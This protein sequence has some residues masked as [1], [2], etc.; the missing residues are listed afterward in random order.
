MKALEN[1]G[2]FIPEAIKQHPTD[3]GQTKHYDQIAFNFKLD[4]TMTV[5]AEDKQ[6]SG[7]FN[8]TESVY[9]A[10]DIDVY[11]NSFPAKVV[12]GKS[13]QEI[14]KYYLSTWRTFQMSDHL[15]LWAELKIDFSN[16]Y[17]ESLR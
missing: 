16:E 17:L 5:F 9:T 3:L 11:K 12:Q 14:L 15:P 10:A 13:E 1:N 6:R 2:F 7:A 4:P 8:F